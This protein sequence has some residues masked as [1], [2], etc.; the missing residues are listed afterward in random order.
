MRILEN[1]H[2]TTEM[3]LWPSIRN[4]VQSLRGEFNDFK[5]KI[6]MIYKH[7]ILSGSGEKQ[8]RRA[9][10]AAKIW[11]GGDFSERKTLHFFYVIQFIFTNIIF[12][13]IWERGS[14]ALD[15][16]FVRFESRTGVSVKC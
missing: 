13:F 15:C 2:T 3:S 12:L 1:I 8:T 6:I 4:Q 11:L 10:K 5:P 9:N 16:I 14:M 7:W